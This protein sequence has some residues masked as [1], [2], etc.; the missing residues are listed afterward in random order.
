[1][2]MHYLLQVLEGKYAEVAETLMGTPH[3]DY[4]GEYGGLYRVI[5]WS[6]EHESA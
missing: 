1:M 3:I 4:M 5:Y 2:K 6:T